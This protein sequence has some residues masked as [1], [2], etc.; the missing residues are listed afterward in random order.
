[1]ASWRALPHNDSVIIRAARVDDAA[2][3]GAAHVESW[4]AAYRG[5]VPQHFLDR[6][7]AD[8]RGAIWK[9]ILAETDGRHAGTFVAES[10]GQVVGFVNV[11]PTRDEDQ[12]SDAV[13]EVTSIYL[14]SA[15]WG[16]GAGRE[17]MTAG[18]R[19]LESAGF[20]RAALWVLDGNTRARR[21][22]E[23]GGWRADGST[24]D[25][26]RLGFTLT[27]VRYLRALH[28]AST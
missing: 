15:A 8:R 22:Y 18:L 11:R 1:V 26:D 25:D 3:I 23:N 10:D 2:S 12:D 4:R 7:D 16:T 28:S 20:T 21:F 27:E 24:K 14:R 13:G 6:L 9:G 19:H 17:L 5:L